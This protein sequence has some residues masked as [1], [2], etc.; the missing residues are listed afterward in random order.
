MNY[1]LVPH[2]LQ[3]CQTIDTSVE[4]LETALTELEHL[5][6]T[7]FQHQLEATRKQQQI[8]QRESKQLGESTRAFFTQCTLWH[9]HYVE[10]R[11][12]L[13]SLPDIEAWM[14]SSKTQMEN[15]E[16]TL[17]YIFHENQKQ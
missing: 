1:Q 14:S 6:T 8:I 7:A 12:Q 13:A 9:R 5:G 10:F 2:H 15:I 4:T 16:T 3:T 11:D 17:E